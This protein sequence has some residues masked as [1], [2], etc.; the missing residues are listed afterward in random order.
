MKSFTI[1]FALMA[2]T[3]AGIPS[4]AA[5]SNSG[6]PETKELKELQFSDSPEFPDS[7]CGSAVEFDFVIGS[8]DARQ[9]VGPPDYWCCDGYTGEY[10]SGQGKRV[11]CPTTSGCCNVASSSVWLQAGYLKSLKPVGNDQTIYLKSGK[12][13]GGSTCLHC[14]LLP[15]ILNYPGW[16][17]L[18]R[19]SC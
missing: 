4:M 6:A 11:C 3:M 5:P 1:P 8:L 16:Q 14:K 9:T 2:A 7:Q 18:K 19:T 13:C 17:S 15:S 10:H 12:N